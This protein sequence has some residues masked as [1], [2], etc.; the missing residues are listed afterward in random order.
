MSVDIDIGGNR[1]DDFED[2]DIISDEEFVDVEEVEV[3]EEEKPEEPK[4]ARAPPAAK[5]PSKWIKRILVVVVV[6][7]L[8]IVALWAFVYIK[9]EVTNIKVNLAT[10]D[11]NNPDDLV[12][13][14]LVGASGSAPIAG[15]ADLEIT[16]DEEVIYTSKVSINDD[17]TGKLILP[18]NNFVE[19]NGNYYFQVEY[20]GKTSPPAEYREEHIVESLSITTEVGNV[21]GNGQLNLTVFLDREPDDAQISV[22][23]IILLD[24]NDIIA[25]DEPQEPVTDTFWE[26]EFPQYE[27][28][29]NYSI[30]VSLEN[31]R[32]KTDSDFRTVTETREIFL[33]IFPVADAIITDI[34]DPGVISPTFTVYFDASSSWNDGS[35]TLYVWDFDDDGTIDDETTIPTTEHTYSKVIS[36]YNARLM[37]RGDVIVDP[38]DDELES[39]FT[40]IYVETP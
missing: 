2:E 37:V 19:S 38:I 39:G 23:E 8:I 17:G 25:Q 15:E 5:K 6:I 26:A 35:I 22:D 21:Q 36:S 1:L 30:T 3:L 7:L 20:K 34:N 16:L 28:S 14:V 27:N 18:Y 10:N 9:T 12:V 33:N 32:A 31:S 40:L 13:T 24:N 4:E 11:P 29:G